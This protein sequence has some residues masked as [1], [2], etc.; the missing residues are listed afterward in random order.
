MQLSETM[1]I[2][3]ART[4]SITHLHSERQLLTYREVIEHENY[5]GKVYF[6]SWL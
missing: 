6:T 3:A 4:I 1:Y 5:L 2:I